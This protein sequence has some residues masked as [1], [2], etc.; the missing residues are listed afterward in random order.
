ML[1]FSF[2]NP[3]YSKNKKLYINFLL[4]FSLA[5]CFYY[6]LVFL[7][8]VIFSRMLPIEVDDAYS[9]MLKGSILTDC[10]FTTCEGLNDIITQLQNQS[11][12]ISHRI[13]HRVVY[14]YTPL[15]A[16]LFFIGS[17]IG[18]EIESI[19]YLLQIL[20]SILILSSTAYFL[21]VFF[22]KL[23]ASL[24]LI[25]LGA[26]LIPYSGIHAIT[27]ATVLLG[28]V[29][30]KWGL[31]LQNKIRG[32][33]IFFISLLMLL[34]HSSAIIYIFITVLIKIFSIYSSRP[35]IN[36]TFYKRFSLIFYLISL[37]VLSRILPGPYFD[38]I[39]QNY[40]IENYFDQVLN[41]YITFKK[42]FYSW[43]TR[44]GVDPIISFTIAFFGFCLIFKEK[45]NIRF[46]VVLFLIILF[47]SVFFVFPNWPDLLLTRLW[48]PTEIMIF[49]FFSYAIISFLKLNYYKSYH[50]KFAHFIIVY[51]LLIYLTNF[52]LTKANNIIEL[53]LI[54]KERY[55]NRIKLKNDF[56]YSSLTFDNIETDA[57]IV[58]LDEI[59]LLYSFNKGGLS[60]NAIYQPLVHEN[61]C[62]F[63]KT[64]IENLY[65]AFTNPILFLKGNL[66]NYENF[67]VVSKE[68]T[69]TLFLKTEKVQNV[70]YKNNQNIYIDITDSEESL[71]DWKKFTIDNYHS[72][73]FKVVP[74]NTIQG[75]KL[76]EINN[77]WEWSKM[78]IT[79]KFQNISLNNEM[80][81][82]YYIN[83]L[84]IKDN[85]LVIYIKINSKSYVNCQ[86]SQ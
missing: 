4:I 62:K 33:G 11:S 75:I 79:T 76:S 5:F 18:F 53:G 65:I 85:E 77:N 64:P 67:E 17:K 24:T 69:N 16:F 82:S 84:N 72:K 42:L 52:N 10:I 3:T 61:L 70:Y 23:A 60:R 50:Y 30:L 63:M 48:I 12:R 46:F 39:P 55:Y 2:F 57:S 80:D 29:F 15:H 13:H 32:R 26:Y 38:T 71:G 28:I 83:P 45:K 27:P 41:N 68:H 43:A 73:S 59:S 37:I 81:D 66:D 34:I 14:F 58:Y 9:Y 1:K 22:D 44:F 21:L 56:T 54:E 40:E 20:G 86:D 8:D 19:Y 51:P 6:N 25:F 78:F 31:I 74:N 49:G 36:I 47:G 7:I 35:N